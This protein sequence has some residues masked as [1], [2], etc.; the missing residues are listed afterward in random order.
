M[1]FERYAEAMFGPM[2]L[3]RAGNPITIG[4]WKCDH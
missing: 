1:D 3:D 2:Y 4:R